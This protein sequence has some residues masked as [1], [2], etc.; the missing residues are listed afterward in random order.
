MKKIHKIVIS[1]GLVAVLLFRPVSMPK[2]EAT[3][4]PTVDIMEILNT[5]ASMFQDAISEGLFDD[6]SKYAIELQ[7]LQQNAEQVKN[8]LQTISMITKGVSYGIEI[9]NMSIEMVDLY[10]NFETTIAYF[11]Q[12]GA[13]PEMVYAASFVLADVKQF[14][15]DLKKNF[16]TIFDHLRTP[17]TTEGQSSIST[18]DLIMKTVREAKSDFYQAYYYYMNRLSQIYYRDQRMKAHNENMAFLATK[19]Y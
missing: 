9:Y 19:Y 4:I 15:D 5:V 3:G 18:M 2:V 1:I 16:E 8:L 12:A 14:W 10:E 11:I 13:Q 6:L 17:S 7:R